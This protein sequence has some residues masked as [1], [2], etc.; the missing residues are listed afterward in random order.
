MGNSGSTVAIASAATA[1]NYLQN[2]KIVFSGKYYVSQQLAQ[3][4][5]HYHNKETILSNC[6][7]NEQWITLSNKFLKITKKPYCLKRGAGSNQ[8][9]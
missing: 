1:W 4:Q 8:T 7:N 9:K 5:I 6:G 2:L 3:M